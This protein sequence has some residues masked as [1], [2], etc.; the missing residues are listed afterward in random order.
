MAV[1]GKFKGNK[2]R[3]KTKGKFLMEEKKNLEMSVHC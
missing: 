2:M 3:G 1:L